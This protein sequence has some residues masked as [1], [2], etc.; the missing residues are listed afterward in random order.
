MLEELENYLLDTYAESE[1]EKNALSTEYL[2]YTALVLQS[3]SATGHMNPLR[4]LK[5][6]K[7]TVREYLDISLRGKFP[8]LMPIIIRLLSLIATSASAERNF[9]TMAFVHSKL[10]NRLSQDTVG[11][12]TY[13]KFNKF[14]QSESEYNVFDEDGGEYSEE[15]EVNEI[16]EIV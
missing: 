1:E 11:K 13:I 16:V 3:M 9:S 12:L 2:K 5:E 15:D 8:L 6:R 4:L 10:R 14:L 7:L